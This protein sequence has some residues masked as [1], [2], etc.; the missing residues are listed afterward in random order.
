MTLQRPTRREATPSAAVPPDVPPAGTP[1]AWCKAVGH[2]CPAKVYHEE[3]AVCLT[4]SR[5]ELC[6]QAQAIARMQHGPEEFEVDADGSLISPV[7]SIEITD[8]MR[9]ADATPVAAKH[10]WAIKS[11]LRSSNLKAGQKTKKPLA[12]PKQKPKAQPAAPR[13]LRRDPPSKQPFDLHRAYEKYV[14]GESPEATAA[15]APQPEQV[16]EKVYMTGEIKFKTV[17]LDRIPEPTN[18]TMN[19]KYANL[20]SAMAAL[21]ADQAIEV[22]FSKEKTGYYARSAL[23]KLAKKHNATLLSSYSPDRKTFYFRLEKAA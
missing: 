15:N 20:F 12:M 23:R 22:S 14:S 9:S 10:D 5:F 17:P 11:E 7:R 19:T 16:E 18:R 4:C 1:C 3:E 21:P 2:F 8:E 6:G 13:R